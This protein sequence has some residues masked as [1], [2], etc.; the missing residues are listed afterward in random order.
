MGFNI[1]KYMQSKNDKTTKKRSLYI[2]ERYGLIV[3]IGGCELKRFS[4]ILTT[5]EVYS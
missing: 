2:K 1:W 4:R 5:T 3:I